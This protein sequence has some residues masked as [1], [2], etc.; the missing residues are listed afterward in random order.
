MSFDADEETSTDDPFDFD[1]TAIQLKPKAM[2]PHKLKQRQ[3]DGCLKLIYWYYNN[4]KKDTELFHRIAHHNPAKHHHFFTSRSDFHHKLMDVYRVWLECVQKLHKRLRS[5]VARSE[6]SIPESIAPQDFWIGCAMWKKLLYW[7]GSWLSKRPALFVFPN[8]VKKRLFGNYS[9]NNPERRSQWIM[10]WKRSGET[11]IDQNQ[12]IVLPKAVENYLYIVMSREMVVDW[13]NVRDFDSDEFVARI[14]NM[15][16]TATFKNWLVELCDSSPDEKSHDE[17]VELVNKTVAK[18]LK[19]VT[20]TKLKAIRIYALAQKL[21][22][23]VQFRHQRLVEAKKKEQKKV[24]QSKRN[25][26]KIG[27]KLKDFNKV[28][29]LSTRGR[30]R[31]RGRSSSYSSSSSSSSSN[32]NSSSKKDKRSRKSNKSSRGGIAAK[33]RRLSRGR[34]RGT[35]QHRG[36]SRSR[37]NSSSSSSTCSSSR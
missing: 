36:H 13:M 32:S 11:I 5:T 19:M 34:G 27:A 3:I 30:G 2:Y 14:L 31:G 33:L 1:P 16:Y 25:L 12:L 17:F 7:N 20:N 24:N 8:D 26:A 10:K 4:T 29:R 28:R 18:L 35:R 23:G 15:P 9:S 21:R 37:G 6:R 22:G